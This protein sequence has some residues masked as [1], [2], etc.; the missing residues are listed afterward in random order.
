MIHRRT[1]KDDNKGVCENLDEKDLDGKPL[2]I[3]TRHYVTFEGENSA[4]YI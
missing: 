4:R 2:R 1:Q 3:K